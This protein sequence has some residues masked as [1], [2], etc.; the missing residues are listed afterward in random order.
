MPFYTPMPTTHGTVTPYEDRQKVICA[1]V[2][3]DP[4]AH[5]MTN[6][7]RQMAK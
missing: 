7:E 1:E 3:R 6:W 4:Y 2:Q 5:L